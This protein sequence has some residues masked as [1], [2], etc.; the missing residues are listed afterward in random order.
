MKEGR[1]ERG[2][3]R[4]EREAKGNMV[5]EGGRRRKEGRKE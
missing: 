4:K 2:R 1:K 3:K 5:Y